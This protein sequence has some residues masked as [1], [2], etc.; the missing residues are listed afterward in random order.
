MTGAGCFR[1]DLAGEIEVNGIVD[2]HEMIDLGDGAGVVGVADRCGHDR[3]IFVDVIIELFGARGEGEDLPTAVDRLFGAVDL[4]G[5]GNINKCVDIHLGMNAEILEVGV[6]DHRAD[7]VGHPA[8]TEL[9]AG[10]V[11]NLLDDQ[12]GHGL[13]NGRRRSRAHLGHRGIVPLHDHIDL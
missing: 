5:H 3:R 7:R 6:R 8:D 9:K 12:P 13:V 2:R 4:S 11:G 10:A 1:V